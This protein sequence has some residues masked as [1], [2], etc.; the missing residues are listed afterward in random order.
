MVYTIRRIEF[1]TTTIAVR[2]GTV[3]RFVTRNAGTNRNALAVFHTLSG[4]TGQ[5]FATTGFVVLDAGFVISGA[6]NAVAGVALAN[7]RMIAVGDAGF[8]PRT[9]NTQARIDAFRIAAFFIRRTFAV[10]RTFGFVNAE[11]LV[12]FFA[13]A[14]IGV[15]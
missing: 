15:G 2:D 10:G 14:A 8:R 11:T 9:G 1:A 3:V 6:R 12:A 4:R 7:I 5:R 13:A